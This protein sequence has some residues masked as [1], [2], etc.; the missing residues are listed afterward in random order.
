MCT[1]SITSVTGSPISTS[2]P[3]TKLSVSGTSNLCESVKITV[4]CGSTSYT[5]IANATS[6]SW[7]RDI[8]VACPCGSPVRIKA[9]CVD[10]TGVPLPN[11]QA[12][13][14]VGNIPCP[15]NCCL[16]FAENI[17]IGE[18]DPQGNRL[19]TFQI[20]FTITDVTCI[21]Y[22]LY[23]DYGDGSGN[24]TPQV[25][26]TLGT[27]TFTETHL[28]SSQ[29][30]STY[31]AVLNYTLNTSCADK[32]ISVNLPA[33]PPQDCCPKITNFLVEEGNCN[34]AC[35]REVSIKTFFDPPLPACPYASMKVEVYNLNNIKVYE[36]P[37]FFSNGPSP[38]VQTVS[39][40]PSD[41][42]YTFHLKVQQPQDCDPAS[43]QSV[44]LYLT[45]CD[46]PPLCP[47]IQS[48]SPEIKDCIKKG[49]ECCRKVE[50]AI[51]GDFDLGCGNHPKPKIRIDYGDGNS[52]DMEIQSGG[53]QQV[54]FT[55]EYCNSGT[56]TVKVKML[57]PAGC[58][59]QTVNVVVPK[60]DS[61]DCNPTDPI[62]PTKPEPWCPCCILLL[63]SIIMF[64]VLWALGLYQE[65]VT[66][67]NV[68]L[69]PGP[70]AGWLF[71]FLILLATLCFLFNPKCDCPKCRIPKCTMYA[72]LIS[73]LIILILLAFGVASQWLFALIGAVT[74]FLTAW[75]IHRSETCQNF[76]ETGECK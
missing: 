44:S 8:D 52:D 67:L 59:E 53:I 5:E 35:E 57:Y 51:K 25:F 22:V 66:I 17:Q 28:Y 3:L 14:Y 12:D 11:C 60:C 7:Q 70:W 49:R 55:N 18:C 41:S 65:T 33:C 75:G 9:E 31:M 24:S 42:P 34:D 16:Q 6:G 73:I 2:P 1:I 74:L 26:S 72:A 71:G 63:L 39:L 56:Y 40:D 23:L 68:T 43:R 38:A 47:T 62:E 69:N 58:P 32:S 37:T 4:D 45:P 13:S 46:H 19:V 30:A 61:I 27:H 36:T 29:T 64:F 21:P 54:I 10:T 15:S 76:W 48:I 20:S 50:F